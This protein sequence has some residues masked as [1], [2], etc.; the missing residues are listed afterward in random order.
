ML[1]ICLLPGEAINVTKKFIVVG[2]SFILILS[3]L[4]F[5]VILY[6]SHR[7]TIDLF[8]NSDTLFL[9]SLYR[10][11][12]RGEFSFSTWHFSAATF[13]FPDWILYGVSRFIAGSFYGALPV[14]FTL[15]LSIEGFLVYM[16]VKEVVQEKDFAFLTSAFGISLCAV[17]I[18]MDIFPFTIALLSVSHFGEVL[19]WTAATWI[20]LKQVRDP[21]VTIKDRL[22]FLV[23]LFGVSFF[24]TASD[25][26]FFVDWAVPTLCSLAILWR[27]RRVRNAT[28]I[29]GVIL[30][31][32]GAGFIA[33][34][35]YPHVFNGVGIALAP[36]ASSSKVIL[37]MIRDF[38]VEHFVV[39]AFLLANY[40]GWF[41]IL[42][43]GGIEKENRLY[44]TIQ[45]L[46]ISLLLLSG[47]T[48]TIGAMA[49]S[50]YRPVG[51]GEMRY[52]AVFFFAPVFIFPVLARILWLRFRKVLSVKI[53][54]VISLG[55]LF[56]FVFEFFSNKYPF[57]QD[58]Y[59][60][61]VKCV[62]HFL[63]P[64][65]ARRGVGLYWEARRQTILSKEHLD[66]VQ[67]TPELSPYLWIDN[68]RWYAGKF[69]FA[70]VR[71]GT[72]EG[73][74]FER[75]LVRQ[76]GPPVLKKSCLGLSVEF[77]GRGRIGVEAI[78]GPNRSGS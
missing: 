61:D 78:P 17:F 24:T 32:S 27:W 73:S 2:L 52:L 46:Y 5:L 25:K 54:S 29:S 28:A 41:W 59:P 11:F 1:W 9:P 71:N 53:L 75:N 43:K 12:I 10:D 15:Q 58:Y 31:G 22:P 77:Y 47:L 42:V 40:I 38:S 18:W 69:D 21:S 55:F 60:E 23:G 66:I 51:D 44:K 63:G 64:L 3:A 70:L 20:V 16:I 65:G 56:F 13:I 6:Y 4:S 50:T 72:G 33:Y 57:Y 62:D 36:V 76:Y 37:A 26:L 67:I 7:L 34:H 74:A 19:S 8:F 68:D 39:F 14:F 45:P 48:S 35:V 30:A 49:F